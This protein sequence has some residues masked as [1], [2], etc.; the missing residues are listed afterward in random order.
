MEDDCTGL[1]QGE[2]AIL[3]SR[4]LPEGMQSQVRESGRSA[5]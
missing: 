2:I 5:C 3:V 4:D 1:K